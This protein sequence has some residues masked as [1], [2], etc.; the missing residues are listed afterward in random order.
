MAKCASHIDGRTP[1]F[2]KPLV[3][4]DCKEIHLYRK[5]Q[6]SRRKSAATRTNR[7]TARINGKPATVAVRSFHASRLP[8]TDPWW[9][10]RVRKGGK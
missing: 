7:A 9:R 5:V 2:L 3:C 8:R 1:M 10:P 4:D 6:T